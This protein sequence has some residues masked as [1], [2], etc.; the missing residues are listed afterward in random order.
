MS[1]IAGVWYPDGRPGAKA[2]CQRINRALALY[3]PHR[4]GVWNGGEIALGHRLMRFL[5]EDRFDRQPLAGK[6]GRLRLVADCRIDNREELGRAMGIAPA[7][8][9]LMCDAAFILAALERW[10]EDAVGRLCGDFAFAAWDMDARTLLLARDHTGARPLHYHVG[11][12]WF[13]FASMPKGLLALP[14]VPTGP[15]PVRLATWQMLFP[16]TGPRSFYQGV[17]RLDV[18]HLAVVTPDGRIGQ[19]RHWNPLA[20]P[21]RRVCGE[22]DAEGLREVLET[23]VKA[24]LRGTGGTALMLS[25]G[26]DSTA[27]ASCAAPLLAEQ[28]RRLSAYTNVPVPGDHPAHHPLLRTDEG[29]LAA[30]MATRHPNIDHHLVHAHDADLLPAIEKM[31]F[32]ADQPVMN[33]LSTAWVYEI[34]SRAVRDGAPVVL[35]GILGNMGLS[36]TGEH[37]LMRQAARLQWLALWR[38][39]DVLISSG[40]HPDRKAALRAAFWPLMPSWLLSVRRRLLNRT[41]NMS[42]LIPTRLDRLG[43][44]GLPDDAWRKSAMFRRVRSWPEWHDFMLGC[45]DSGPLNAAANAGFGVDRRDPTGDRRVLEFCLSLPEKRFL[46]NGRCKDVFRRAFA[47]RIPKEILDNPQSGTQT[48]DWKAILLKACPAIQEELTRQARIGNCADLVD[49]DSL[50]TSADTLESAVTSDPASLRR[51]FLK[52]TR[53]LSAGI[54]IRRASGGN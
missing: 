1:A 27:V 49:L 43:T 9:V 54:F 11:Q 32:L 21:R 10:G 6:G 34:Y 26:M 44:F 23:A 4:D 5:P 41:V 47:D 20:V 12:G 15:D 51:H 17:S 31:I 24:Q 37:L 28:G 25:S 7:E 35:T 45:R 29:P 22:E 50:R 52:L 38:D 39:M 14:D 42:D 40:I 30:L 46:R 53:G 8:Q 19:R 2:D 48:A 13:A 16:L 33:P 36:Y 3:G 18:G